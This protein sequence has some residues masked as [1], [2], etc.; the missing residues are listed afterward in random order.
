MNILFIVLAITF[1][2]F[3]F[4]MY[5][6]NIYEVKFNID[7][8][9]LNGER[10]YRIYPELLNSFGMQITFRTAT[11]DYEIISNR[12]NPRKIRSG[13]GLSIKIDYKERVEI[14]CSTKF[15]LFPEKIILHSN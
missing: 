8:S 12:K 11:A 5:L 10:V 13:K 1:V 6:L 7:K 3:I 2:S 14:I 9:E 15:N 4:W